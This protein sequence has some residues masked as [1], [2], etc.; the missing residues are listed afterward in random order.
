MSSAE[1]VIY[2]ARRENLTVASRLLPR[3]Y[4]RHLMRVY[5][6]AR[7][8]DDIGDEAQPGDRLRL[9]D[10]VDEEL[11][12]LYAGLE[13]RLPVVRDLGVTVQDRRIPAEPFKLLVRAGRQDQIVTRYDTFDELLGHCALSADP[14][15][16]I[17]LH[18]FGAA[19]PARFLLADKVCSALR[20]I[21]HCR[22]VGEDYTRG[23][24]YL[25]RE[26]LLRHG[27]TEDDFVAVTTP[28]RLRR[29]VARQAGRAA[30]MLGEGTPLVAALTGPARTTAAGYVAT[31]RATLTAL[32]RADHDVLGRRVRPPRAGRFALWL[33]LLATGR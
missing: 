25:P 5:A 8:V 23:R 3:G 30:R 1:G 31:G 19:D 6:F 14:I 12:R 28:A 20:V 33:R 21:E 24:I 4:R 26:D 17:V 29:V 18:V 7:L 22:D 13:P 10:V 16:H 32:A 27:C 9:F 2:K 15:G 11:D